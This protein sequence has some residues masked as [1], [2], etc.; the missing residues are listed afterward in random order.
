MPGDVPSSE[1]TRTFASSAC[2]LCVCVFVSERV[3]E[4]GHL[5]AAVLQCVAVCCSLLQCP[6]MGSAVR[7]RVLSRVHSSEAKSTF[8]CAL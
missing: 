8:A 3:R 7:Q 1:R 2:D 5:L 6:V 4:K